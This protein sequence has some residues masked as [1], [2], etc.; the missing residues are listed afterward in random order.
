MLITQISSFV[1]IFTRE[2]PILQQLK[3]LSLVYF[4]TFCSVVMGKIYEHMQFVGKP[5]KV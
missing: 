5:I 1:H 2:L 4:C 3:P